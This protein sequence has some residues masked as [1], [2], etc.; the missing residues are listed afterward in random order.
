LAITPDCRPYPRFGKLEN[1]KVQ[2]WRVNKKGLQGPALLLPSLFF[3]QILQTHFPIFQKG[4][5]GEEV[6]T[7]VVKRGLKP[8][9]QK[10][11]K[12]NLPYWQNLPKLLQIYHFFAVLKTV[13][14][15]SFVL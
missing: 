10:F 12:S 15:K 14:K 1:G 6:S 13:F 3:F 2:F 8:I 4:N 9:F 7:F 5:R 11:S